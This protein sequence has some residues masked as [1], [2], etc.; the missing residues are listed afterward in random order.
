MRPHNHLRILATAATLAAISAPAAH[1]EAIS[2][3]GGG[4]PVNNHHI[5]AASHQPSS[6]DWTLIALAG[7][8]GAAVVGIG[9]G[10]SRRRNRRHVSTREA[11]APH[12]A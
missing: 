3:G 1:A 2:A 9:L 11:R 7:G 4:G 6:T 10:A 8:G 5:A 12:V